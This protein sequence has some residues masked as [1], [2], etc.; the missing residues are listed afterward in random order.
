M[1]EEPFTKIA[2]IPQDE[3]TDKLDVLRKNIDDQ[4]LPKAIREDNNEIKIRENKQMKVENKDNKQNN[5]EKKTS[6]NRCN[7]CNKKLGLT[8]FECKCGGNYCTKHRY[9]FEHECDYDHKKDSKNKLRI[10]L[11]KIR[12]SQVQQI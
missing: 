4:I 6:R 5:K 3:Q 12:N 7:F 1:S 2:D 11:P 10:Q 9:D 8:I